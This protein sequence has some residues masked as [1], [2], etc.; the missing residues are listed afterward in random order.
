[1]KSLA[2]AVEDGRLQVRRERYKYVLCSLAP[3]LVRGV[4]AFS[5]GV[6]D[7]MP[8]IARHGVNP[9]LTTNSYPQTTPLS[10]TAFRIG[11]CAPAQWTAR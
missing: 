9:V 7:V 8:T 4:R 6:T 2:Q 10:E 5:W 1:M 3:A 11:D